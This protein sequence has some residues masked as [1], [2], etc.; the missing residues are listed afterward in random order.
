MSLS[1]ALA[2][3]HL[4]E[5][6]S[7]RGRLVTSGV[8][9]TS[10][11]DHPSTVRCLTPLQ[12]LNADRGKLE[13]QMMETLFIAGNRRE[14]RNP[15]RKVS[16]RNL[17]STQLRRAERVILVKAGKDDKMGNNPSDNVRLARVAQPVIW[18]SGVR[19]AKRERRE[20]KFEPTTRTILERPDVGCQ[21]LFPTH[22]PPAMMSAS[23]TAASFN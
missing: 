21:T 16:G 22:L 5:S 7:S 12:P 6:D 9:L 20:R 18:K 23:H 11:N 4:I 14:P 10:S 19:K 3:Q 17:H 15:I 2:L 8:T 13:I 1:K